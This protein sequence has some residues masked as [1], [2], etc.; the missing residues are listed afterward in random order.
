MTTKKPAAPKC[1]YRDHRDGWKCG[2]PSG[3]SSV[4]ADEPFA[5]DAAPQSSPLP[6]IP[7]SCCAIIMCDADHVDARRHIDGGYY[8]ILIE[9]D[10]DAVALAI[11]CVNQVPAFDAMV[12]ALTSVEGMLAACGYGGS[13]TATEKRHIIK[14]RAAL[15]LA[16]EAK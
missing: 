6:W 4:H 1:Q 2:R 11:R 8:R 5:D 13:N 3:H 15:K 7:D 16:Q 9:G 10:P 12:E 14:I